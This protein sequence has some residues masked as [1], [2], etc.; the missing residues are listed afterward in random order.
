MER[1]S[2]LNSDPLLPVLAE[3]MGI[4][5]SSELLS[6]EDMQG[7]P[8]ISGESEVNQGIM[9]L[10]ASGMPPSAI[11]SA[12]NRLPSSIC[13][14]VRRID[15]NNVFRLDAKGRKAII[16]RLAEGRALTA[17][18]SIT[19]EDLLELDADKRAN[20][21]CKMIK[22]VQDLNQTKH[23]DKTREKLDLMLDQAMMELDEADVV[24]DKIDLDMDDDSSNE[25]ESE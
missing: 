19:L 2:K 16:T 4:Q 25:G 20:V 10:Y 8:D 9:V 21:A 13:R 5:M 11:A 1:E 12:F 6:L 3:T 23:A 15:P 17:I 22:V 24:E 7:F 14:T 18:S